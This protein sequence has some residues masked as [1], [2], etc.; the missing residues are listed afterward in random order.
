M[1]SIPGD[2]DV[3]ADQ[4]RTMVAAALTMQKA[5]ERLMRLTDDT[6]FTSEATDQLRRNAG[7][8]AVSMTKASIRYRGA[9][10]A[11]D[12]F[13]AQ[14]RTLQGEADAALAA[15]G[16]TDVAGATHLHAGLEVEALEAKANPFMPDD[17][18]QHIALRLNHAQQALQHEQIRAKAAESQWEGVN[19]TWETAAKSAASA[20]QDADAASHLNEGSVQHLLNWFDDHLQDIHDILDVVSQALSVV[21]LALSVVALVLAPTIV[22][23]PLAAILGTAVGVLKVITLVITAINLG[24]TAIQYSEGKKSM[25]QLI[26]EGTFAVVAALSAGVGRGFAK[27]VK[28]FKNVPFLKDVKF[29]KEVTP[30]SDLPSQWFGE[31]SLNKLSADGAFD[32]VKG[33][34]G[35]WGDDVLSERSDSAPSSHLWT[36]ADERT[37]AAAVQPNDASLEVTRAFAGFDRSPLVQ[38]HRS[39]LR[40]AA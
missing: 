31:K 11:L 30:V 39:Q 14:L 23:T 25:S 32:V 22:G 9:G 40:L 34:V 8:L 21:A 27:N 28:V 12:T 13:S 37:A 18:R 6:D 19:A 5:A 29:L 3:I 33:L 16:Q 10:Q 38:V 7:D 15:H 1:H 24:I 26:F 20:I 36:A 4:A 35:M 17:E 2:P